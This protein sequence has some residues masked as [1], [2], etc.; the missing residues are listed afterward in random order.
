M[1]TRLSLSVRPF[2]AFD[3]SKKDHRKAL[4][5]YLETGSWAKCPVQFVNLD[6]NG[7]HLPVMYARTLQYYV[8]KEF[9]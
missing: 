9:S 1:T 6:Q 4:S 2:E 3:P 7:E 5:E 8:Q